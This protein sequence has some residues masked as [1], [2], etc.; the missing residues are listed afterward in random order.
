MIGIVIIHIHSYFAFFHPKEEVVRYTLSLSNLARFSVPVFILSSGAFLKLGEGYWQKK[1]KSLF[2][3]FLLAS[4]LGYFL[5]YQNKSV[6]EF[7][8]KFFTGSV[9]APYYFVP[10]LFQFY[11]LFQILRG[12]IVLPILVLALLLNLV[13]NLGLIPL[14][15][16]F[17]EMSFLNFVFFFCLGITYKRFF[18]DPNPKITSHH[19]ILISALSVLIVFLSY[20]LGIELKNH[21]LGYPICMFFVLVWIGN[22]ISANWFKATISY[23]GKNSIAVFLL[24]P[25]V[26]H[27]MHMFDPFALGGPVLGYAITLFLNVAIPLLVWKLLSKTVRVSS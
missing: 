4:L 23:V 19:W 5:K 25:F 3:P 8:F 12:R 20:G 26:I 6:L 16:P 1:L 13:S 9:F 27:L 11:L 10:L 17:R 21:H 15:S 24:H 7:V 18:Y 14:P 22:Q 2:L